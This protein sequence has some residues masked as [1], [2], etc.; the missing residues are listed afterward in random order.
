MKKKNDARKN[1]ILD[2]N[3]LLHDPGSILNFAGNTVILPLVVLEELDN[4]KT[5]EGLSGYQARQAVR[6]LSEI[7]EKNPAQSMQEGVSLGNGITLR[8]E[9]NGYHADPDVAEELDLK[10]NDNR[11]LLTAL[12][13]Q[14]REE[15][16]QTILVS[17]DICMRLKAEA[18]GIAAEDYE[19]DRIASEDLYQGLRKATMAQKEIDRLFDEG[20]L[21]PKRLVLNPNQFVLISA[22]E[23][24]ERTALAR[25]DG[26]YLVPLQ[27]ENHS[28]WGLSPIN[29]EQKLAFELMMDD[30]IKLVSVTGGAGSGKT[31]LATAVALEKVLEQH[32]YRKVIFIRPVEP[33][34]RDIG[35]LPGSEEEKLRPWMGSFYDAVETLMFN[36]RSR[37]PRKNTQDD[38]ISVD[39]MLEHLRNSGI[40]EMKTFTYMRG[41]TLAD[42]LVIVDEAQETTPHLAKLML[43]RAGHNSKF[44]FLGD[45]SDNQ[46]DNVLVDS[47]SNGLVYLVERLKDSPLTGHITLNQVERSALASLA[48]NAL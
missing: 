14:K 3:V 2:T 32:L 23:A 40:I 1:Y 43:T 42:A 9:M 46:I 34:G 31:I 33:A 37:K 11:I 35:Y 17:K 44:I 26:E 22:K 6:E 45:P 8:V 24:P 4:L 10:K 41:R 5:R 47:R 19:T 18:F 7:V 38:G 13:I 27:Y 15:T 25:F 48:E 36:G 30:N 28:A 39:V 12:R 16:V 21:L 29:L 20:K